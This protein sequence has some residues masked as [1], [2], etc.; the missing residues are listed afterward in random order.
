VG[1]AVN[2]ATTTSKAVYLWLMEIS[3]L[4]GNSDQSSTD[5]QTG[6]SIRPFGIA[7]MSPHHQFVSFVSGARRRPPRVPQKGLNEAGYA[8]AAF[9]KSWRRELGFEP[10]NVCHRHRFKQFAKAR[11]H[12]RGSRTPRGLP[13][14]C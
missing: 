12:R 3:L 1:R 9:A 10:S 8:M 13:A 4:A 11:S 7:T 14:P 5:S 2:P 6:V